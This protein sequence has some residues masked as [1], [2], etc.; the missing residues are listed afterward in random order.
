MASLFQSGKCGAINTYGTT[1]NVFYVIMFISESYT[2]QNNTKID[3]QIISAGELFVKAQYIC[4]IQENTNWYRKQQ[5]PQQNIIS[6]A[7]TFL[8]PRLDVV[9]ITYVQYIPKNVCNRF[10]AKK[11]H[12]NKSYFSNRC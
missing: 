2:L 5:P 3:R 7:R 10:Q 4:Y 12:T 9:G 11:I 6:P 1:K 8:H